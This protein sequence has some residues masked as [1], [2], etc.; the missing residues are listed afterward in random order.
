LEKGSLSRGKFGIIPHAWKDQRYEHL[1]LT[2]T[3]FSHVILDDGVAA[4][5][6]SPVAETLADVLRRVPLLAVNL[7]VICQNTVDDIRER[8][9]LRALR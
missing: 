9:Q 8:I 7:S 6:A 3:L 2:M 1:T 5:E 4:R